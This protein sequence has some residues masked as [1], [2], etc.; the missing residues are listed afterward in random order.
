MIHM[1]SVKTTAV[2]NGLKVLLANTFSLYLKTHKFHWNVEG[3]NF[4]EFHTFFE[5]LY[6]ELWEAVDEIAEHIRALGEFS[7]GSYQEFS[8]LSQISEDGTHVKALAMIKTLLA[9]HETLIQHAEKVI[10]AAEACG[11]TVTADFVTARI[12]IHQK[13]AWMLR[14]FIK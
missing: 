4:F 10:K 1:P 3:S 13:H 11:D 5:K 7:P 2:V 14:S 6:N 12:D 9:D 8:K